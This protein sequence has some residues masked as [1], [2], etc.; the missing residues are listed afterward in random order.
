MTSISDYAR[1]SI[2]RNREDG[3]SCSPSAPENPDGLGYPRIDAEFEEL[4]AAP[5]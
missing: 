2:V 4:Q 3:G 1:L 5:S